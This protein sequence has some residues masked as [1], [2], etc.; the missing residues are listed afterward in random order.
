MGLNCFGNRSAFQEQK[1][2]AAMTAIHLKP[3]GPEW[4]QAGWVSTCSAC[5]I[6]QVPSPPNFGSHFAL[7]LLLTPHMW[8]N[9]SAVIS[10]SHH[11]LP[12]ASLLVVSSL[13]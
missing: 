12:A 11:C 1:R 10:S 13:T 9:V 3:A 8:P 6:K 7:V 5:S 4:L 2:G